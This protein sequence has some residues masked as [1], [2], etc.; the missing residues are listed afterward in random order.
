MVLKQ[1][2]KHALQVLKQEVLC[3]F[4]KWNEDVLCCILAIVISCNMFFTQL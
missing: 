4:L 1:T 2:R 3:P